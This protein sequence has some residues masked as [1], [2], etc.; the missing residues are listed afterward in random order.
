MVVV[1]FLAAVLVA[2]ALSFL[3]LVA[4]LRASS[5]EALPDLPSLR[6]DVSPWFSA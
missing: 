3:L 4:V 2:T 5:G 6:P 1:M